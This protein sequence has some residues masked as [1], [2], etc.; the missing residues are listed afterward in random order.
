MPK[1]KYL[2]KDKKFL[3]GKNLESEDLLS[4]ISPTLAKKISENFLTDKAFMRKRFE[5]Y[6]DAL[7]ELGITVLLNPRKIRQDVDAL[8][9]YSADGLGILDHDDIAVTNSDKTVYIRRNSKSGNYGDLFHELNHVLS[10]NNYSNKAPTYEERGPLQTNSAIESKTG[11]CT[12]YVSG[13]NEFLYFNE[14]VTEYLALKEEAFSSKKE[15]VISSYDYNVAFARMLYLVAGNALF[16][17][18]FNG[19]NFETIVRGIGIEGL[20]KEDIKQFADAVS[21][22][23][24]IKSDEE[25]VEFFEYSYQVIINIL[26]LKV[27]K[28]ICENFDKF[29]N[30]DEIFACATKAYANFAKAIYFGGSRYDYTNIIRNEVFNM[31]CDNYVETLYA[32]EQR[33]FEEGMH[34]KFDSGLNFGDSEIESVLT[35]FN[36][37]NLSNYGIVTTD[38]KPITIDNLLSQENIVVM[39]QGKANYT[40]KKTKKMDD[41]LFMRAYGERYEYLLDK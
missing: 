38:E 34:I 22:I 39:N 12:F 14:G 30:S 27:E 18:Y 5:L 8:R 9:I 19:G 37:I 7:K 35:L 2:Y 10:F 32:I 20:T 36:M 1:K 21:Q 13:E 6:F 33:Y 31:F 16:D 17:A 24:D 26:G 4:Y 11:F 25:I 3:S 28:E 15:I 41:P 29:K 23:D 40:R